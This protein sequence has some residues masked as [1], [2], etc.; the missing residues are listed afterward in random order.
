[1]QALPNI[2]FGF[3]KVLT[4]VLAAALFWA[5]LA[6]APVLPSLAA[7][8]EDAKQSPVNPLRSVV[9]IRAKIPADARTARF[10]GPERE[11]SGVVIDANGLV[12]TIGY[13]I[14]QA[15][16]AEVIGP[17]K[18]PVPA[19]VVGYDH[20]TGFGLLRAARPLDIPPIELGDSA[21]LIPGTPALAVSFEGT[22][23]MVGV[24]IAEQRTFA[25]YWEYL[26]EDA[27]F[28]M[29]PHRQYGGAALIGRDGKLLGI[30]SLFVNDAVRRD[31]PAPGNMFVP[32]NSLKPILMDLLKHGR[33]AKPAR[34]WLGTRVDDASGRV[35]VI[36]VSPGGPADEAGIHPA[37][38]ILGVAGRRVNSL[39]EFYRRAWAQ[40]E[41]GTTVAL[42][43]VRPDKGTLEIETVMVKST[44]R[45]QWLNLNRE[46]DQEQIK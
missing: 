25:G 45:Y 18:V 36:S 11:G 35:V 27:I 17:D 5:A 46:T 28:T 9:G 7:A 10:L 40:G 1:M 6:W 8:A 20:D 16:S 22:R 31:T 34:P 32:I 2:T 33:P 42:D 37:D 14:L 26:L 3:L 41:A 29:P 23:P 12:L 44:S 4:K 15:T 19:A 30:G 43:L 24:R 38:V 21:D 13:L 39:E